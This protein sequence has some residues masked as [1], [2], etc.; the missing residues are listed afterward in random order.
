MAI[1]GYTEEQ[2]DELVRQV[3]GVP[4]P[5][6]G[7]KRTYDGSSSEVPVIYSKD[8]RLLLNLIQ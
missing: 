7:N 4:Q 6:L 3:R 8:K 1:D 2:Y 5:A